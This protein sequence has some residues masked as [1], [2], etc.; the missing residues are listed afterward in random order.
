MRNAPPNPTRHLARVT[1]A[2]F[3]VT[4]IA[5]RTL[6]ILITTRRI[7]DLFLHVSGTHVHHLNYGIFLLSAICGVLLFLTL[8]N[9]Q[10]NVCAV[11]YG[12]GLGLIAFMPRWQ[13]IRAHH[14]AIGSLLILAVASFYCLLLWSPGRVKHDFTPRLMEIEKRG[15]K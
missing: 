4:F 8:N 1:F 12:I 3:F 14:F 13:H 15:P 6:V 7:P 5:A 9:A 11:I 10:R 2:A